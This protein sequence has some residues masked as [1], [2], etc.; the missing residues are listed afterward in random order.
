MENSNNQSN[1]GIL[2]Y[3]IVAASFVIIVA[4]MKA[5]QSILVPF[6]LSVFISIICS[7]LLFWLR[8]KGISMWVALT[9]V[10]AMVLFAG[11]LFVLLIGASLND[12]TRSVPV[13]QASL[14]EKVLE[15]TSLLERAGIDLPDKQILEYVDPGAVM[16]FVSNILSGLGNVLTNAFLIFFTVV[17]ILLEAAMFQSKLSTM[18]GRSTHHIDFLGNFSSNI[19]RYMVIKTWL[20][21]STGILVAIWLT[22][23]GVDFAILWGLLAFIF[24]FVPN[25]G[26]I[27][28]AI[29][30]I[31]LAYVQAGPLPAVLSLAGYLVI[32]IGIGNILEPRVMGKGLGLSTLIVFLSLVFWGWVLGPVGML[33]SVPLTTAMKIAFSSSKET[34]WIGILM[35]SNPNA[36]ITARDNNKGSTPED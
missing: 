1:A 31:L 25:I 27:I 29:P 32:N 14:Q 28:A 13:Y 21:L 16:N 36:E 5:A 15:I 10:I 19:N 6:F 34:Q 17:F 26:S 7:P 35:D 30:A 11:V 3:L 18:L 9:S 33:L 4:G 8:R 12:F 22:I 20:S 23:L 2:K 24:N